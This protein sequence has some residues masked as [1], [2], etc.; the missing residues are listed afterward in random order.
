VHG[1]RPACGVAAEAERNN[2]AVLVDTSRYWYNYRH[3]ANTLSFYHTVKRLG[4]PDSH[5]ILMLAEDVACNARNS[6]PG[7]VFNHHHHHLNLYGED[8][9]VDYRGDEVSVEN[10]LRLLTGRHPPNTPRSK[11]LLTD[12]MSN[13]FIFITG[14]S[15]EEFIKFQD[16]E[17]ITSNDI[18]DGFAQMHQQ[19]RYNKIFWLSDTCQAATLQNQFYS[20]NIIAYGSSGKKENSYSHHVDHEIGVA[21]IDRFTFY[22]FEFLNRLTTTSSHTIQQFQ[23]SFKPAYLSSNPELRS[24]LFSQTPAETLMTEFLAS[25]GR[26]RFQ[27]SFLQLASDPGGTNGSCVAPFGDLSTG[28]QGLGWQKV[29]LG[30]GGQPSPAL[31]SRIVGSAALDGASEQRSE[32]LWP[33]QQRHSEV[34]FAAEGP[35]PGNRLDGGNPVVTAA[36]LL[37]FAAVA[38][39]TSVLA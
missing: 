32:G 12:S 35:L 36:W 26:M 33:W 20:P 6:R 17:E 2:W 7:T 30:S 39:G 19:R 27:G 25:T 14:H 1:P 8:V 21:V 22:A 34:A 29:L 31:E 23:N 28:S 16:W 9:E 5:I 24:D 4:I 10:F 18:A 3:V 38:C 13:I 15:G 37:A 11:R